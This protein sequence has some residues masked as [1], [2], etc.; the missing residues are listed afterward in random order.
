MLAPK[1]APAKKAP[2]KKAPVKQAAAPAAANDTDEDDED[3]WETDDPRQI[4]KEQAYYDTRKPAAIQAYRDLIAQMKANNVTEV[5]VND[6]PSYDLNLGVGGCDAEGAQ[7]E[8]GNIG[9][10]SGPGI[11]WNGTEE[12]HASAWQAAG[13]PGEGLR[14]LIFANGIGDIYDANADAPAK[15]DTINIPGFN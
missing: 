9:D 4:A 7:L 11:L 1:N 5:I 12:F 10:G 6:H 8:L 3:D 2:A 14:L 13:G 15:L